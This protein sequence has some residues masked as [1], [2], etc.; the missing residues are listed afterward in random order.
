MDLLPAMRLAGIRYTISSSF[1]SPTKPPVAGREC[2]T[3]HVKIF[4]PVGEPLHQHHRAS[5]VS[6]SEHDVKDLLIRTMRDD[7]RAADIM[8]KWF[9]HH[10]NVPVVLTPALAELGN[11]SEVIHTAMRKACQS[12]QANL[13][14]KAIH[15]LARQDCRDFWSVC[16]STILAALADPRK[17]PTRRQVADQLRAAILEFFDERDVQYILADGKKTERNALQRLAFQTI[18]AGCRLTEIDDWMWGWLA[19]G[20][21]LNDIPAAA[22]AGASKPDAEKPKNT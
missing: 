10:G 21:V 11:F 6:T 16:K 8:R 2:T 5:I 15:D 1:A 19:E 3:L 13:I 20:F 17:P 12:V 22:G 14:R 9:A 18:E 7:P 4:F